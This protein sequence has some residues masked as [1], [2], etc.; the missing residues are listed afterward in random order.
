M[1]RAPLKAVVVNAAK[2]AVVVTLLVWMVQTGKLNPSQ[3]SIF[4]TNPMVIIVGVSV[5]I[6]G[7][8]L[9]GSW[10][11]W[12]LLRGAG[13][14]CKFKRA[15]NLQLVGFFFNTAMPGAV[16]GDIVKAVYIIKDQSTPSGKT[17]AMLSVLLDRIVGLIGLFAMGAFTALL[18]YKTMMEAP[19]TANLMKGLA[20][21][22]L[23]SIIFLGLVFVKYPN[24]QDPFERF[25]R[26][27]FPGFS[28][29]HGIYKALRAYRERPLLLFSTIAI[30]IC[31]QTMFMAYMGFIGTQLYHDFQASLL[32]PIFPFGTL[33]TAVPLAPG[34]LGVGHAAFDKLFSMV[35]LPGGANVFNIYTLSQ[36][37]L[38][39]LCFIPY[40]LTRRIE[41]I[42]LD[43]QVAAL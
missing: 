18:N 2:V 20:F 28:T 36:L 22:V 1:A 13:L 31:I 24:A 27:D 37:G 38:N 12:L 10:R 11:W 17:P 35:G 9:L 34:G 41:P 23:C 43:D 16:G 6:V 21:V 7:P 26:L 5:W 3:M 29:L 40:L 25:L 33:V 32:T 4:V 39:L 42:N 30:S 19:V 15:L 14:E 8:V